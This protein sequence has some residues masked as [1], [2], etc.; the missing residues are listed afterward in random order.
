M[1]GI[2]ED[3]MHLML[4]QTDCVVFCLPLDKVDICKGKKG[5]TC[6]HD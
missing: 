4:L 1:K 6:A 5:Y 3:Q 2:I